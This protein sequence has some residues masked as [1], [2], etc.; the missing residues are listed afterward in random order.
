MVHLSPLSL[1]PPEPGE[2]RYYRWGSVGC[3][4]STL[5]AKALQVR[6]LFLGGGYPLHIFLRTPAN[7]MFGTIRQGFQR[8]T[9]STL[10]HGLVAQ[11]AL[12]MSHM[13]V[14][15]SLRWL[16]ASTMK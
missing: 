9:A 14:E 15:S 12:S 5:E 7:H 6:E 1:S 8:D 13:N 3:A 16:S 11:L 4:K 2:T 10:G